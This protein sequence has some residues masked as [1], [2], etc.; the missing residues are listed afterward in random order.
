LPIT[1][2]LVEQMNGT[3]DVQSELDK[4]SVFT[5]EF[6]QSFISDATIGAQ[7]VDNLKSFRYSDNKRERNMRFTRIS[8]PYA[9]VL[10]VDDHLTNLDVAK[11]FLRPYRMHVDC[12]TSGQ[13]A[14][15]AIRNEKV[16]Y[17]AIFMDHMM[18]GMDGVEALGHIRDIGTEYAQNIPIIAL[19]ANAIAGNEKMFLSKGFQA[20]LA[21]PINYM[22]L[23]SI[24]KKWV[25]D[26][27][28][29]SMLPSEIAE[30]EPET[31]D[32]AILTEL[33]EIPGLN[34]NRGMVM[35]ADDLE[36]YL[37]VLRSYCENTPAALEKLRGVTAANL[38]DYA[39]NV[40]G[41]KGST[42]SIGAESISKKGWELESAAKAGN[43]SEVLR[44]NEGFIQDTRILINK[45]KSIFAKQDRKKATPHLAAPDRGVLEQLLHCLENFDMNGVDEAMDSLASMEYDV[46]NDLV[47][48][49]KVGIINGEFDEAVNRIAAVLGGE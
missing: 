20:F 2:R 34:T 13:E 10:V 38:P 36:I 7:V 19:T 28:K 47:T 29:E 48:W 3:I 5:V 32:S 4:G 35:Y 31:P 43:L 42:A 1:K 23:D 40:H 17:N 14:I 11:G 41:L 39:I 6:D 15:D 44:L 33:S 22:E 21:K 45:L 24:V 12:L 18:P 8:L 25:R 26:K 49:L 9:H 27:S 37:S 46:H 16:K 30:E